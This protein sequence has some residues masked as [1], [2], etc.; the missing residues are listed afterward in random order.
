MYCNGCGHEINEGS[1]FCSNCGMKI[2][3]EQEPTTRKEKKKGKNVLRIIAIL[4]L[5]VLVIFVR[6]DISKGFYTA[7]ADEALSVS[8]I[9]GNNL[10]ILLLLVIDEVRS[11]FKK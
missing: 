9:W 10:L 5:V 11:L 7:V 1:G 6:V 2:G 4:W 8:D 3:N